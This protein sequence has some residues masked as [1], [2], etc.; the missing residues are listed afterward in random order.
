MNI[1]RFKNFINNIIQKS[2]RFYYTSKAKKIA[3]HYGHSLKVNYRSQFG[4][5]IYFGNN[6]NFNGIKVLGKGT[7]HFGNNFH[8]G[9]ECMIITE[10]HK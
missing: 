4:G 3:I 7:V 5:N 9:I 2:R 1:L 6:C 10:N 8:S